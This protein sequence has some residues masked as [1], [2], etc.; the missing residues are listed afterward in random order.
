MTN[1]IINLEQ[2]AYIR[3][4]KPIT[5]DDETLDWEII[6]NAGSSLLISNNVLKTIRRELKI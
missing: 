1:L 5:E 4:V 3:R 6:F 2:I